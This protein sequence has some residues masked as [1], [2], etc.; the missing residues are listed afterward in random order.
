[1]IDIVE[2]KDGFDLQLAD[3]VVMKAANVVSTQIGTLQYAPT[4]GVDIRYFL[5][6]KFVIQNSTF[7]A[8]LVRQLVANQINVT[9]CI[10]TLSALFQDLNFF[11]DDANKNVKGLIA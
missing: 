5:D 10:D 7:K 1:M 11:V 4:F 3:S 9:Q 8:Y 2:I 6:S